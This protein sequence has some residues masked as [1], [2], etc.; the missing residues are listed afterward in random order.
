MLIMI[1]FLIKLIYYLIKLFAD[2]ILDL[3]HHVGISF[4]VKLYPREMSLILN[5]KEESF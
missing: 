4:T 3:F 1:F 2:I 5:S